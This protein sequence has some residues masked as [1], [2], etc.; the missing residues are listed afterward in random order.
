MNEFQINDVDHNS[1]RIIKIKYGSKHYELECKLR[2]KILRIPLKLSLYDED[3]SMEKNQSH[4]VLLTNDTIIG[5]V[6]SKEV[7][8]EIAQIR[9]MAIDDCF[10][11]KGYG[12]YLLKEVEKYLKNQGHNKIILHARK[13]AYKFYKKCGYSA[14]GNEFY[15]VTIPHFKMTKNLIT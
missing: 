14:F 7:S 9:Q 15:E 12:E 13:T 10:Q 5:C 1:L 8:N 6:I 3:L 2:H 4:F 11:G